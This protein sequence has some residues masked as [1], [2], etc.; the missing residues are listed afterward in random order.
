M[1]PVAVWY[2]S[3]YKVTRAY[4]LQGSKVKKTKLLRII[5]QSF[6]DYPKKPLTR[7][8]TESKLSRCPFQP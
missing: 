6:A 8:S 2:I 5:N 7:R 3:H 4:R 1:V